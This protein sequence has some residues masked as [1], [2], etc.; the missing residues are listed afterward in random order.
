MD[1]ITYKGKIDILLLIHENL[2][3]RARLTRIAWRVR[4]ESR[5]S[6]EIL[7]PQSYYSFATDEEG[8][9]IL[10]KVGRQEEELLERGKLIKS[11]TTSAK[12]IPCLLGVLCV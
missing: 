5:L 7:R 2:N 9:E 3:T 8:M 11:I 1:R 4:V 12:I 10:R 6:E